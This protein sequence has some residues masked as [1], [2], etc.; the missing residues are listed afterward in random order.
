[1]RNLTKSIILALSFL[2]ICFVIFLCTQFPWVGVV[3]G[4]GLFTVLVHFGIK[5]FRGEEWG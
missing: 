1:M 3:L 2:G 4:S 5:W